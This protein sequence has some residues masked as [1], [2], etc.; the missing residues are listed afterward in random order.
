MNRKTGR[1][2]LF[3]PCDIKGSKEAIK[4]PVRDVSLDGIKLATTES[5]TVGQTLQ[6]TLGL[7]TRIQLAAEVRWV[8][9][10]AAKGQYVL[11]CQFSHSSES[12]QA[13][14]DTLSNMASAID[15]SARRV[16]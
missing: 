6:V 2:K 1:I 16:R 13:L 9:H 14:K 8:E 12:R 7:P 11:G 4:V 3:F 15:S 5:H 10:D